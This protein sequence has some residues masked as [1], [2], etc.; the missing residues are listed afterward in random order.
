M[1]RMIAK[2]PNGTTTK[3]FL[4][5]SVLFVKAR[6]AFVVEGSSSRNHEVA[7]AIGTKTTMEARSVPASQPMLAADPLPVGAFTL[8][9]M[10]RAQAP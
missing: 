8:R 4:L 5:V 7:H 2:Q 3:S 1:T 6:R 10:P 9:R